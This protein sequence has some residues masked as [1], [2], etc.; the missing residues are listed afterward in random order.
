MLWHNPSVFES[1][2]V[3]CAHLEHFID[4]RQIVRD[5]IEAQLAEIAAVE[6]AIQPQKVA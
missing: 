3:N 4:Y 6:T 2:L 5:Q 1:Y